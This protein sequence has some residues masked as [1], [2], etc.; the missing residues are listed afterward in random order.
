MTYHYNYL[1]HNL[2]AGSLRRICWEMVTLWEENTDNP[3]CRIVL[4]LPPSIKEHAEGDMCLIFKANLTDVFTLAFTIC[5][6]RFFGL[7]GDAIY[8]GRLQGARN[9]M[10]L[11]RASA[12]TCSGIAQQTLLLAAAE[13]IC[14]SLGI[15]WMVC[16]NS[17]AQ[18][19]VGRQDE[20]FSGVSIYD[21]FWLEIGATRLNE[22]NFYLPVPMP[23]KPTK[24]IKRCHRSRAAKRRN[25]RN[26]V[27]DQARTMFRDRLIDGRR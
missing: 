3:V 12:K 14:L 7:P 22:E 5:H 26:A 21:Q 10:D 13:G 19:S 20:F 23:H 25:Y 6:G 16:P 24:H 9:Q 11:I 1:R 4:S 2:S 15:R 17:K 8:V 27:S 18:L